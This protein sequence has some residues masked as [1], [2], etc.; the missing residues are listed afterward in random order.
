MTKEDIDAVIEYSKF[1]VTNDH[2]QTNYHDDVNWNSIINQNRVQLVEANQITASQIFHEKVHYFKP[3]A[4]IANTEAFKLMK[5]KKWTRKTS[6]YETTPIK[7][8]FQ[9]PFPYKPS[10]SSTP[11]NT[12]LNQTKSKRRTNNKSTNLPQT[13]QEELELEEG[14]YETDKY[15]VPP[16]DGY[17]FKFIGQKKVF[18]ERFG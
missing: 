13:F 14:G 4:T 10:H 5:S 2:R 6:D 16:V 17:S 11:H 18:D 3:R 1:P 8:G 12:P 15:D 9:P 7:L